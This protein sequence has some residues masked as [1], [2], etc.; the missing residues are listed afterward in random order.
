M[1][2]FI[3]S[4]FSEKR[5]EKKT[6]ESF[7]ERE[8]DT[9]HN[10]NNI[11]VELSNSSKIQTANND[12]G[13]GEP[14]IAED[15]WTRIVPGDKLPN[16]KQFAGRRILSL[17]TMLVIEVGIPLGLYYG[18]QGVIG[19]VYALV[20]S[21][22][23]PVLYVLVKFIRKRKIDVLGVIIALSFILSGIVSIVSG[24]YPEGAMKNKS[25]SIFF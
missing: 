25:Q 18:L 2:A 11:D 15:G 5:N 10:S 19:I 14:Y 9:H 13:G 17:I 20:V 6:Y 12:S 22:I 23:P 4:Y 3:I 7:G 16:Q 8:E 1:A 21:G 24:K